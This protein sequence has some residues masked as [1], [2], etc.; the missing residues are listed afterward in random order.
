MNISPVTR[1]TARWLD[2]ADHQ[3]AIAAR[4]DLVKHLKSPG[5]TQDQIDQWLSYA[6]E[7]TTLEGETPAEVIETEASMPECR[8]GLGR[9]MRRAVHP[10]CGTT[11]LSAMPQ[12]SHG[13]LR[14]KFR[15]L[16]QRIQAVLA[17]I[18]LPAAVFPVAYGRR[19]HAN[20]FGK[21]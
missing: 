2:T 16:A 11:A 14:R 3:I 13:L 21:L 7:M 1:L 6:P 5:N 18:E 4:H 19:A 20:Q 17:E 15:H 12:F 10:F 8:D 9:I